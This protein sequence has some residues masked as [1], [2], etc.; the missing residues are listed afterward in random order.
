MTSQKREKL[1]FPAADGTAKLSGRDH[2]FRETTQ[3][4]DQLVGSADFCGELQGEPEGPQPT[5][6]KDDAE[7]RKDFWCIQGDFINRHL[8][9]PRDTYTNLDV[10]QETRTDGYW[11]VDANWSL[12]A[13]W[14]GF[15][16]FTLLNEKPPKGHMWSGRRLAKFQATTIP[17]NVWPEVINP[18]WKSHS[19][20]REARMGNREA[21][22]R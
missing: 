14:K 18:N 15:T 1:I 17:E 9:D 13:S 21:Q 19:T 22:T 12:P 10:L 3:R 5:E 4:R 8:N 7:A 6:A 11:T 20:E 16:K 2:E